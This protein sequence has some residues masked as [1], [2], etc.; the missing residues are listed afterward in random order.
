MSS[1]ISIRP[2]RHGDIEKMIEIEDRAAEL[3]RTIGYDYCADAPNRSEA[4]HRRAIDES[5]TF[6]AETD[7]GELVG[8]AMCELLDG[9]IHLAEIDVAPEFQRRGVAR[10]LIETAGEW[11]LA[12]NIGEMTLTTYRDAPWNAPYYARLG[13]ELFSPEPARAGLVDT[14]RKEADWG[15]AFAPRVAMRMPLRPR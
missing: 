5:I 15:F 11:A 3:F 10:R 7:L 8:F 1:I 2:A 14:I 9:V 6:V 13:F 4:E 12:R